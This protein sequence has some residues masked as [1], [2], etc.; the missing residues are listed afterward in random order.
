MFTGIIE[1][2][3]IV[4][5]VSSIPGGKRI[6]ISSKRIL[7]DMK[8]GDSIC[9]NGVCLTVVKKEDDGF[10]VEAVGATLDKTTFAD[11]R[12]SAFVNLEPSLRLSD[13]L[14]GHFV[15]GHANGIGTLLKINK[16][17][18]NYYLQIGVDE[19]LDKYLIAEGSISIDGVSLTI[20]ELD[21]SKVG[22]SLIP[23][24][25]RSTAIQYKKVGDKVNIETDVLAKYIEKLIMKN[26]SPGDIN[27]TEN[28]LKEL[29]Y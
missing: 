26:E 16:L 19:S 3:G 20:S 10:W 6:K 11:I 15:L 17:G 27:I 23:F 9:V 4:S 21:G 2:I 1:E 22:I 5:A 28:W 24:T 12:I 7:D 14:G 29:G 13:R 18:D 25:W 8:L